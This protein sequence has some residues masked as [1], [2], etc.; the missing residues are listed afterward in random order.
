M[1]RAPVP[2]DGCSHLGPVHNKRA[3]CLSPAGGVQG[4]GWR[5]LFVFCRLLQA[6][7]QPSRCWLLGQ[8]RCFLG[9]GRQG[10]TALPGNGN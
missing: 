3:L 5:A 7:G 4:T 6:L 1:E 8:L 10:V 9:D 2:L